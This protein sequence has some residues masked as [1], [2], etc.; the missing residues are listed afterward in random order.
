[1]RAFTLEKVYPMPN[2]DDGLL[3][4]VS[5]PAGSGKSTLVE[6]LIAGNPEAVRRAVTATTRR[7]RPGEAHGADY[8]FL[9][10]AGFERMVDEG[11]FVEYTQFNGKYYGT[12][13]F[14][15][16]KELSRGGIVTLVLEVNGAAAVRKLFPEAL[17]VFL[18]PPTPAALRQRL[19]RR[20]TE[21]ARDIENRLSIAK[22]EMR[23]IAD[24]DF[25]IVND[26]VATATEDLAAV[27]RAVYRSLIVG[28]ELERW[29]QGRFVAWNTRT[30]S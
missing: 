3:V 27:I 18:I 19:E 16:D 28:N 10:P 14:S 26:D 22:E 12:P 25:L 2:R 8:Y 29:E 30:L 13:R 11:G 9:D 7:P 23:R 15:L 5:G 21:S 24:Y 6:R 17:F 4:V 1:M 20:G